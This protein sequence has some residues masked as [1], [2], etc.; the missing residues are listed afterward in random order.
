MKGITTRVLLP[1][2]LVTVSSMTLSAQGRAFTVQDWYR[3]ARVAGP[4]LSP[5]GN[6]IAFTVTTVLEAKN[7]R[8]TE[9][10]IQPAS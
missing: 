8:H 3:I 9:I 4:T 10:W 5:D 1:L 6:T 2:A 7:A